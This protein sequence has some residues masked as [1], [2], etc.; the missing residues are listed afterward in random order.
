MKV[1]RVLAAVLFV[2]L[3][4][5]AAGVYADA[6]THNH[7]VC[8]KADCT[9]NHE[10]VGATNWQAWNGEAVTSSSETAVYLYLEKDVTI[11]DTLD[12][13]DGTVYL[14]LNGKTLT[15]D[16]AG[17]PAVS[18]GANQKFVLCDC[19][20][21]GKITGAK[22]S[23]EK[24]PARFGAVNCKSGSNFVMYGGSI[25]DNE[26]KGANGGGIFVNGGTFTMHGGSVNNNKAPNGSGGAVSVENGK[27]YTY[28]GEMNGNSAANGGAMHIKGS[29][30]GKIRNIKAAGNTSSDMGGAIF[31]ETKGLIEIHDIELSGNR[32]TRG[33]GIYLK[34]AA[35]NIYTNIYNVNIHDNSATTNGNLNGNGGG[36]FLDGYGKSNQAFSI[37][38]SQIYDNNADFNGGG[39]FAT[40]SAMLNLYG[41]TISG[42]TCVNS[43][44]GIRVAGST[45]FAIVDYKNPVYINGNTAS[46]GG[47]ISTGAN[48]FNLNGKCEIVNNT[49]KNRGGG[50]YIN[51]SSMWLVFNKTTVTKNTA[52]QGGGIYL[53]KGDTGRDLE[54][55]GGTTVIGNTSSVNGSANNLYLNNGRMFQFRKGL[56]GTEKVGVSVP[57]TPTLAEPI[58]IEWVFGYNDEW[59]DTEGD[60]SNLIIPDND[61]YTAIYD[62]K[63]KMHRLIP[64]PL[65]TLTADKISVSNLN[66]PAVL[67]VA[68]YDGNGL[69]DI[70]KIEIGADIEKTIAETA[71]NTANAVKISAFLWDNSDGKWDVNMYPLCN[72]AQTNLKDL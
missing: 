10:S 35:D 71:L 36:V 23:A 67:F 47:G 42:N 56:T 48:S 70:K 41:G 55:V 39:I 17:Y 64:K 53:D 29:T 59:H 22:G 58:N 3:T 52:P 18:V 4:L 25:A 65:L 43:G 28:G 68:S 5:S 49:A 50:V 2:L 45:Y 37:Y 21:T 72:G 46:D 62:S 34:G 9:E 33:G 26:V 63:L 61:S 1:K 32:A 8:G 54:I 60:R 13:A 14:C 7:C 51:N 15:I 66:K 12:I 44:G 31:T 24:D 19:I 20:G 38:D 57:G 16:K 40:E 6:D 27:I 30:A 11:T 69:L